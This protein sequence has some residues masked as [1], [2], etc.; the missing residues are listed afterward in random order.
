MSYAM[1]VIERKGRSDRSYYVE[2]IYLLFGNLYLEG[3]THYLVN[4]GLI[5][6]LEKA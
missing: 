3:E 1:T 2:P 4:S 5:W 6:T